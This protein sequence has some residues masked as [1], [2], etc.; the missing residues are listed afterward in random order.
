MECVDY[1]RYEPTVSD[2]KPVSAGFSLKVKSVN[3]LQMGEVKQE[4]RAEWAKEE[5]Q[6]LERI[7]KAMPDIL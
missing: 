4:L 7:M 5:A 2:H 1:R 6:I 3:Q